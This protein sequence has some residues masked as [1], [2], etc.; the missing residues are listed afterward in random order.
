MFMG[1]VLSFLFG[2]WNGLLNA[3]LFFVII[4]YLSGILASWI[5]GA[6]NSMVGY[7]GVAK[8]IGIFAIVAVA[9]VIDSTLGDSHFIRDAA[10]FFYLANE[11]L[12]ITEN[13]G[14]IGVPI[15]PAVKNAVQVLRGKGD[16]Q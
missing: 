13:A 15:P 7:K 4:D 5:E 8:K 14:R 12:S 3:L 10:I 6:L 9:H 1:S 2:G 16:Q 11:L